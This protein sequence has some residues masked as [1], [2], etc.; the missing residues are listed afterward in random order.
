MKSLKGTKT[1]QNLA[2]S[3]AAESCAFTRYTFFGKVAEKEGYHQIAKIFNET[4]ANEM[5]HAKIF[6]KYLTE[7]GAKT[8]AMGIDP[9]I[10]GTTEDNLKVAAAEEQKE[11]IDMYIVAGQ[12]AEKEGFPEIAAKF[13]LIASVEEHH[14]K[15]FEKLRRR[16]KEEKVWKSTQEV[17]WQ[18]TVCGYV[19]EGTEPPQK[20]PV[21]LHP[22][23]YFV[24]EEKNF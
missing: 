16:I 22:Y 19:M 11:G 1:E 6:L 8:P 17:M 14:K 21:C 20:C 7:T 2:A 4:A 12:E 15:R 3:Y 18:C 9:G 24:R 23:Q 5:H 13:R 10:L